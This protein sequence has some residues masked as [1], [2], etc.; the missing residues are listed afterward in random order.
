MAAF[1]LTLVA[2]LQDNYAVILRD[3]ESKHCAIVDAPEATPILDRLQEKGWTPNIVLIT[4]K[5]A[6]HIAGVPELRRHYPGLEVFAPQE[7]EADFVDHVVKPGEIVEM[8]NLKG[9]VIATPGHTLGHVA[10]HFPSEEIVF[11]GDTLFIMGC[12]R[13]FEG[14]MQQMYDALQTLAHL[15]RQTRIYCGHEYTLNNA[16]FAAHVWP[17]NQAISE[18]Y[19]TVRGLCEE[20]HYTVPTILRQ[21]LE[22]NPFLMCDD[23]GLK[24]ALNMAQAHPVDVFAKL[25]QMKDSF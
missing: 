7:V 9:E 19:E 10:Y 3:H 14:T 13:V 5:H 8:G 15:P 24:T 22:T 11:A 20:G 25:R 23:E 18:R 1:E 17:D 21:E 12:G 4:H 16:R 2:C 6:D